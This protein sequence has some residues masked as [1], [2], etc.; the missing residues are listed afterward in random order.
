VGDLH[1][2]EIITVQNVDGVDGPWVY[3][4]MS[5]GRKGWSRVRASDGTYYL[6]KTV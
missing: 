4:E 5:D 6:K 2:G 3:Y 1:Q